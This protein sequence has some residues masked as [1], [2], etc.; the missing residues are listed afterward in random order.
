MPG[1]KEQA[2]ALADQSSRL[3]DAL[4]KS[5]AKR[6]ANPKARKPIIIERI[7]QRADKYD[8]PARASPLAP[9]GPGRVAQFIRK[10]LNTRKQMGL[11]QAADR[12]NYSEEC[13]AAGRRC[14]DVTKTIPRSTAV[15]VVPSDGARRGQSSRKATA[16]IPAQSSAEAT[17]ATTSPL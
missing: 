14:C 6:A 9:A 1:D 8:L 7:G 4:A 3:A 10:G 12:Q 5:R 16:I 13:I 11:I 15:V 2:R 17:V